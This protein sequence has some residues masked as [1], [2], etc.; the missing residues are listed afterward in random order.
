MM[1]SGR[2]LHHLKRIAPD[3]RSA[4]LIVGFMAENTLGRRVEEKVPTIRLFGEEYPLKA[5]VSSVPGLSG[6]ADRDELASF[7][8]KLRKPPQA[9]FLVHGEEPQALA[10]AGRLR[11]LGFPRVEVPERGQKFVI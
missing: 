4:I 2:V 9:A 3:P 11:G 7:L 1:E 5:E 8:G 10:F 6:H